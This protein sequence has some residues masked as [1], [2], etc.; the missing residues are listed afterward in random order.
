MVFSDRT[1][2][3]TETHRVVRTRL[4]TQMYLVPALLWVTA[5]HVS[6]IPSDLWRA[7][8]LVFVGPLGHRQQLKIEAGRKL[9]ARAFKLG[10]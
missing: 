9:Y 4:F 5:L 8:F 10:I 2:K 1:S 7:I 6:R 3:H